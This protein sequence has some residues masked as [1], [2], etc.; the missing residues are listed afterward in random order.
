MTGSLKEKKKVK[1]SLP[2]IPAMVVNSK[3]AAVLTED[4]EVKILSHNQAQMLAKG[5]PLLVCHA[6]YTSVKLGTKDLYAYDVLE[7]FAFIYPAKFCVPTPK[8]LANFLELNIPENFEDCPL[9]LIEITQALLADFKYQEPTED[10]LDPLEIAKNMG[11]QGRGWPWTPYLFMAKDT[12]YD[13]KAPISFKSCLNIIKSL[14][15]WSETAPEEKTTHLPI[16][17]EESVLRLRSLLG[18]YSEKRDQQEDYT[19]NIVSAFDPL[20]E[21]EETK[22]ILA[23]AGTGVGKTLGYLS[24]ASVWA[25]K[26]KSPVWVSTYTKNLQRQ[27]DQEL[28][29][30]FPNKELKN[31]KVAIRKGRENYLCLLNLEDEISG[32]AL[33]KHPNQAIAA[34]IMARWTEASKDGDLSGGDYP[35]W[36]TGLLGFKHSKNLSDTRG[37][38]IYS[39]CDHY[40]KC[41]VERAVRKANHA[42]IVVANHALVMINTSLASADETLPNRYIFDEGHHLFE[43]ADSAFASHLTAR[44]TYDLRRWILGAEGGKRTR[45]RGL[46]RRVEDLVSGDQSAEDLLNDII[47]AA[48]HLPELGWSYRLR[49]KKPK[50]V[51]ENFLALIYQQV[52]ARENTNGQYSVETATYPVIDGIEDLAKELKAALEKIYKPMKKLSSSLKTKLSEHT[53]TLNSDTRKRLESVSQSLDRRSEH[54]IIGWITMLDNLI[55]NKIRE[56]FIDWMEVERIEGKA[57]DVGLY[58]HWVDPMRPFTAAIKPHAHGLLI[59]SAT[60]KGKSEIE[61]S[62]W[63]I[64]KQR[65]GAQYFHSEPKTFSISSPFDYQKQTKIFVINDVNKNDPKQ[66]SSAFFELFTASKGGALGLFTSIQRLKEINNLTS[67]RLEEEGLH[68]YAQHIDEIDTGTLVDIFKED[69]HACLLGTDAVRDGVDV[70][71]DALRLLVYDRVPWPRPTLVH[72]ARLKHFGRHYSDTLTRLKI[73]QAYG[74]LIRKADDKGVFVMLDSALPTRLC[75]AFPEEVEVNRIGIQEALEQ[76]KSFL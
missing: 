13:M 71:G 54:I 1:I 75:S 66:V 42:E 7:L 59:T 9:S 3:N 45:A 61:N 64:A 51:C 4:G 27:I 31:K 17:E 11:L 43:A 40:H 65:T 57:I 18:P 44:E 63:D 2:A 22:Q 34:G 41:F 58:R 76:I 55:Q 62:E 14:P 70:P 30:L 53:D 15:E 29:K 39:A 36:L 20:T 73:Q 72:K 6:P 69:T 35:G 60:L 28:D 26:N 25:E 19:K 48:T 12:P 5:T 56:E 68:L 74:R 32:A 37:E 38:C 49:D 52:Y 33:A 8:G 47:N 46:K 10:A 16:S 67:E 21:E 23:Q 24:P 50:G